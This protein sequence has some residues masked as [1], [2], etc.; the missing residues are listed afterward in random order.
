MFI[1]EIRRWMIRRNIK[2]L[3]MVDD[4]LVVRD[5]KEKVIEDMNELSKNLTSCGFKN[6]R[7][8]V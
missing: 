8:K 1:S 2:C 6:G 3:H 4:R 5:I 7:G